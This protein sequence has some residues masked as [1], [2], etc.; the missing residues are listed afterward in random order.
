MLYNTKI[1]VRLTQVC[2]FGHIF[3][4]DFFS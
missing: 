2:V 3:V 4:V 1:N